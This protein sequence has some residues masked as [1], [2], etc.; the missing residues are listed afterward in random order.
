MTKA[1]LINKDGKENGQIELPEN[2][3]KPIREDIVLKVFEA[4]KYKQPYGP[5]EFAGKLYSASGII[6]RK[7]H[8]WKVSYGRGIS[9]VPRKIMSRS[10]TNFNWV[11][12]TVSGTRGGRRS[13]PPKPYENQFRKIN[14][15]E[16]IIAINSLIS[17]SANETLIKKIY[18]LDFTK[19]LPIVF[20]SNILKIETNE[21]FKLLTNL[22]GS[23]DLVLKRKKIRAGRGKTRGRKYK[24]NAGL[25]L[26]IGNDEKFK[27][28]GIDV[29]KT[30][31]LKISDLSINGKAGRLICYTENSIKE[32]AERF[33]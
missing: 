1:N 26:V 32:I 11:G 19:N 15:K 31:D 4:K 6:G 10:G 25:L 23:L 30:K 14:K 20:N 2:F 29:I 5:Y 13:H 21:F 24:S 27:I 12:A 18:A 17:A 7:R 8:S 16:M 28:N 33:K 3:S 22:F 9:R